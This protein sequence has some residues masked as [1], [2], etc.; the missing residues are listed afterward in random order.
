M[1]DGV[2]VKQ[3]SDFTVGII[4]MNQVNE[5]CF[6]RSETVRDPKNPYSGLKNINRYPI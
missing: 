4:C 2:K 5:M 1:E 6:S 3:S